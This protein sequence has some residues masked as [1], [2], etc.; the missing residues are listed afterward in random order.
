MLITVKYV[1]GES[2]LVEDSE[3]DELMRSRKIKSF[4]RL[5]GWVTVGRDPVR[6]STKKYKG[7]N[8]RLRG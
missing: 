3:L 6:H 4:L 7:Q 5:E 1:N 2:G 8:K